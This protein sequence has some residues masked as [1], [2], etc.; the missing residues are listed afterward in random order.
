MCVD[1]FRYYADYKRTR[2]EDM[3]R[4]ESSIKS[5]SVPHHQIVILWIALV[6]LLFVYLFAC[7]VNV[8]EYQ[9]NSPYH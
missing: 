2:P 8:S 4:P 3:F 6:L 5:V 9:D 1:L 7:D